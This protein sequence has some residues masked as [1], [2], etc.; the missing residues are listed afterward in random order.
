MPVQSLLSRRRHARSVASLLPALML[1]RKRRS[2]YMPT[3]VSCTIVINIG[4]ETTVR[5][6]DERGRSIGGL[7]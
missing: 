6:D 4:E 7:G 3:P 2:I 5:V 1:R